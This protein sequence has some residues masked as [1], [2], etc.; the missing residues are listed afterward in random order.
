MSNFKI[1]RAGTGEQ[2]SDSMLGG[3]WNGIGTMENSFTDSYKL[4]IYLLYDT[5]IPHLDVY[6]SEVKMYFHT[7]ICNMNFNSY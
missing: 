5:A 1:S 2:N 6:P 7:K 3:M 4:N